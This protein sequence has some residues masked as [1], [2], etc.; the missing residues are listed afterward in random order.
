[1]FRRHELLIAGCAG[2]GIWPCATSKTDALDGNR[3]LPPPGKTIGV[4]RG[5]SFLPGTT[6]RRQALHTSKIAL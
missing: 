3:I 2:G 6:L 1:V 5:T 4:E